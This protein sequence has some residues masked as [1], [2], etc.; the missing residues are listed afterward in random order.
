M[1]ISL[2]MGRKMK[3]K[4]DEIMAATYEDM[5]GCIKNSSGG[6]SY[7]LHVGETTLN[8]ASCC[9]VCENYDF[10]EGR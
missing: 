2:T 1:I 5:K 9:A 7:C 8:D 4:I 6:C 10:F 3:M